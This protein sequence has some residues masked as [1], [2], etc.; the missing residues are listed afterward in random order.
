MKTCLHKSHD[1]VLQPQHKVLRCC[2]G[3]LGCKVNIAP[4]TLSVLPDLLSITI[5]IHTGAE[6]SLKADQMLICIHK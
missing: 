4:P 3:V 6:V 1:Q 2:L 5:Y